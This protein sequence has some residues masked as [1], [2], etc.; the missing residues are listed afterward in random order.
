MKA[1]INR[2]N[3]MDKAGIALAMLLGLFVGM[4]VAG[5]IVDPVTEDDVRGNIAGV[6]VN[7]SQCLTMGLLLVIAVVVFL[8]VRQSIYE[9]HRDESRER[10]GQ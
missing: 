9:L 6:M 7:A 10:G 8:L 2:W 3:R 5:F 4:I 1:I